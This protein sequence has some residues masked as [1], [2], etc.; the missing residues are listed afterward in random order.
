MSAKP[1]D[2]LTF[3]VEARESGMRLL[4]FLA[5]RMKTSKKKAKQLLDSRSVFVD[6]RRVWMAH[7][8]L[9]TGVEV[10][11]V[12]PVANGRRLPRITVLLEDPEYLVV[13]KPAG[14]PSNG[15]DSVEER[16]RRQ[17]E[18]PSLRVAHRLDKDTTGCLIVAR[19]EQVFRSMTDA[20][21]QGSVRKMYHA[22]VAGRLQTDGRT[23]A[24]PLEGQRAVTHC[25]T[26]D[27]GAEAS[28][29]LVRIDTGRTHQ[30]RKHFASLKH[31]VL[32]DRHYATG[33]RPSTRALRIGRQM[34]HASEVAFRHPGTG[35][36]T[37][38]RAPLPHDFRA[39]LRMFGLT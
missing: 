11:V 19:S 14:C 17:F 37:R 27:A 13:N 36:R 31:P 18:E 34:L 33:R 15:V 29:V 35:R 23:I 12:R 25:K 6:R 10:D 7:H 21:R 30:I 20:F 1:V 9:E 4:D 3:T 2:T 38:V 32:G 28:H 5:Q 22:I 26:L 39:C 8:V 16:L 24:R